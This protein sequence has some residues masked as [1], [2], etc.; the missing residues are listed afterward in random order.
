MAF[1]Q[2]RHAADNVLR[3]KQFYAKQSLSHGLAV[4]KGE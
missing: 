3:T 4:E 2:L 1:Q